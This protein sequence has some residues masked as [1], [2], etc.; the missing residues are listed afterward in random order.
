MRTRSQSREQRP[1][2]EEPP[3]IIEPLRIEYPFQEDPHVEPMADTRTMAQLLQAPTEGYE[4]AILIPEIV[5]NNF[6]LKHGLINLVQN[7]QFFGHDK[8][9]PHAHIRYFNKITSTMRVPNVPIATI[10]LMLFPFSIEG[11]ARIWLEKEPPRSIQTWDDLVSKFINQFFPPSKTTNLRNEITRFQQRFD[12][13]F[14]E[15]WDRFNDLLRACP[16]HG[17]SELH[18]LD[19]FYNALN[20][21]DQDSLNSAAGGNF[22]DKMPRECLK[23]IESK[24]K[25]RQTRAKAVVAKVSTNS[26]TQAV[27]SDV[28][29]LKDIVRALLLDKKNQA[30]APAPAPA[31]VKAVELSCVTCGGAHSYQNCPATHG[32]VYRD[33]ISEYVSQAAAA[34]YN[35]VSSNFRPQMVANHIRPPGFPPVQNSQAN[36]ANNFNRGNN[37]NQNRES[38]FNQNRGGNFNQSNFSQNQLHRPQVNQSPAYQ[39]PVPQTHSVTR[40]GVA[41]QG[42]PIPT[43]S[44]VKPIPEV[45]KDQVHPSCSQSTAPVQ[46]PVGPE[47]ITTPVFEPIV[48]PVVAPVPNTKPSVSLPYPS[49]RD[50]EKSRNQANEQIDKFYE[51]FKEMSFEIS[52]TDALVLMPKFASTLRTLLGNKEKL[53]EVARTSNEPCLARTCGSINF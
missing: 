3:V 18:Q 17:F 43:S 11:A 33:N 6:E 41:Y 42:P 23:I 16:H 36:N 21:N 26:S 38:N 4:D 46:P 9:D 1:P 44:V 27:S 20:I 37:F 40:S 52:F 49:R 47:P 2:P 48:A 30:S 24:S 51:I 13:S 53:T 35:Q 31:P 28:A 14:Y 19:T 50:N 22:L 25:V 10:K 12:E 7:K 15:A 5:A 34:N 29:E 39:A 8:E 32:N 45:T